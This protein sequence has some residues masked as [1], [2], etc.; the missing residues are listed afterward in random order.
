MNRAALPS[1]SP[2]GPLVRRACAARE[3][4]E[5]ME[6]RA[7][8][9]FRKPKQSA[10]MRLPVGTA[11]A[12]RKLFQAR[13]ARRQTLE[14]ADRLRQLLVRHRMRGLLEP[15]LRQRRCD[16]LDMRAGAAKP[17]AEP[18]EERE[19]GHGSSPDAATGD[20]LRIS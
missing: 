18:V 7:A 4:L 5:A 8:R 10:L 20:I 3:N 19:V 1:R 13:L 17:S 9:A 6:L 14:L 15:A 2:P 11:E 12:L 16:G